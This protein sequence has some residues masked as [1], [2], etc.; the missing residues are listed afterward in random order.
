MATDACQVQT[1]EASY[2]H[3]VLRLWAGVVLRYTARVLFRGH[4]TR[5]EIGFSRTHHWRFLESERLD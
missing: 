3:L 4:M 5:E 2:G 1:E